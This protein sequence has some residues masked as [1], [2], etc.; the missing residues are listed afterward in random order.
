[1][2][3]LPEVQ[4]IKMHVNC[5]WLLIVMFMCGCQ[6]VDMEGVYELVSGVNGKMYR[7]NKQSGDI[8]VV[9]NDEVRMLSDKDDPLGI[10]KK[11]GSSDE[12]SQKG[13]ESKKFT[14]IET[15]KVRLKNTDKII[16]VT[17]DEYDQKYFEKI[18]E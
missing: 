17:A 18:K 9:E 15:F 6:S 8:A 1:M 11:N 16:T 12:K 14:I 7:I 2:D 3:N 4:K 13:Y 10:M 5:F